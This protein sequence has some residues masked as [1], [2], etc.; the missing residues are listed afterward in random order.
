MTKVDDQI[1]SQGPSYL[2]LECARL[3]R[4]HFGERLSDTGL[5]EPQWRVLA[6]VSRSEGLSQ[7]ELALLLGLHK[8]ALGEQLERLQL[9]G[10]V[11]RLRDTH[12][13]RSKRI[14]LTDAARP[15]SDSLGLR[16]STFTDDLQRQL[17]ADWAALQLELWQLARLL[18]PA[19]TLQA[20]DRL[21]TQTALHLVGVLARLQ[22]RR[23]E[24]ILKPHGLTGLQ[25][26]V[27]LWLSRQPGASQT[28]LATALGI[29]KAA[30]GQLLDVLQAKHWLQRVVASDD[31]RVKRLSLQMAA[32][33]EFQRI[34]RECSQADAAI[35]RALDSDTQLVARLT[36]LLQQLRENSCRDGVLVRMNSAIAKSE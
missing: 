22:G 4:R 23:I 32:V 17:A 34:Q 30:L 15:L 16:F 12:D 14:Y 3:I 25:W 24:A 13:R 29:N 6:F 35:Y 26:M 7:T 31:K 27:L 28:E 36:R 18:C 19:E 21:T 2:L 10:L 8:V 20:L 5:T 1:F 9:Q 33:P 11:Q